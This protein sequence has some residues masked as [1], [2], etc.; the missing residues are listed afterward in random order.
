MISFLNL[1]YPFQIWFEAIVLLS[2]AIIN[3]NHK[4]Y[5]HCVQL[6]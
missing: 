1:I 4:I 5:L 2:Q 3:H 6:N